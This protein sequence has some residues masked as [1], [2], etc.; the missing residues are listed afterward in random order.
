MACPSAQSLYASRGLGEGEGLSQGQAESTFRI[1]P[2]RL[3]QDQLRIPLSRERQLR[4]VLW[5][6]EIGNG[7]DAGRIADQLDQL[8]DDARAGDI[9]G[10]IHAG[11]RELPDPFN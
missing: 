6:R 9:E 10:G 2:R 1:Q 5:S 8:G 11:R 3:D 4:A 7:D